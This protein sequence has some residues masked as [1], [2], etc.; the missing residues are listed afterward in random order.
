MRIAYQ[1]KLTQLRQ[2]KTQSLELPPPSAKPK[3]AVG[4]VGLIS[5]PGLIPQLPATTHQHLLPLTS[6]LGFQPF[7]GLLGFPLVSFPS[8]KFREA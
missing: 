2:H 7:A 4:K 1:Y 5:V 3:V 6:L 8:C